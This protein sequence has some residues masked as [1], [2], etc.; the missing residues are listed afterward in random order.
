MKKLVMLALLVLAGGVMLVTASPSSGLAQS[1]PD[2]QQIVTLASS[3]G[4]STCGDSRLVIDSVIDPA[5]G[6][7]SPFVIPPKRVLVLTGG[8]WSAGPGI[9]AGS[10]TTLQVFLNPS[11]VPVF[12]P[13]IPIVLG[14]SVPASAA[15]IA[16]G[17]FTVRPGIVIRPGAPLCVNI[18]HDNSQ[19]G[20]LTVRLYGYLAK[21]K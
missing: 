19:L 4:N 3:S 17:A 15:G 1:D 7:L 20:L 21:D 13:D 8:T 2:P 6:S 11:P 16:A 9:P 18:R 5:D 14:P 12:P 10:A